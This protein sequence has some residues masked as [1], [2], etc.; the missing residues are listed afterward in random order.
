MVSHSD[1][2][3]L[4]RR[5]ARPFFEFQYSVIQFITGFSHTMAR[6]QGLPP[7]ACTSLSYLFQIVPLSSIVPINKRQVTSTLQ[8]SLSRLSTN[9]EIYT[10][11]RIFRAAQ[12]VARLH[13]NRISFVNRSSPRSQPSRLIIFVPIASTTF[14]IIFLVLWFFDVSWHSSRPHILRYP[15]PFTSFTVLVFTS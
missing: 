6:S 11:V 5:T 8:H 10:A 14:T 3:D 12:Q 13:F 9:D 2:S 7:I 4:T 15:E 1:L